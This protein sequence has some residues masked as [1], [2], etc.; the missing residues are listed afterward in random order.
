MLSS[1]RLPME[2]VSKTLTVSGKTCSCYYILKSQAVRFGGSGGRTG[3]RGRGKYAEGR[4]EGGAGAHAGH[5]NFDIFLCV[6]LSSSTYNLTSSSRCLWNVNKP[7][8]NF[9]TARQLALVFRIQMMQLHSGPCCLYPSSSKTVALGTVNP[10]KI[11]HAPRRG[12]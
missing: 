3:W 4:V 1:I 7:C 5:A 10:G 6:C 8:W 9:I 11:F 2:K 12:L